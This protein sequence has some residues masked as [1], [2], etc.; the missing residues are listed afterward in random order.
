M[1]KCNGNCGCDN[2]DIKK[3]YKAFAPVFEK[4][5]AEIAEVFVKHGFEKF[6]V[7]PLAAGIAYKM[8]PHIAAPLSEI[9]LKEYDNAGEDDKTK[10]QQITSTALDFFGRAAG[11]LGSFFGA[12][13]AANAIN[14]GTV[15]QN[16][17]V[18]PPSVLTPPPP[19]PPPPA[20]KKI[21]GLSYMQAGIAAGVVALILALLFFQS[22]QSAKA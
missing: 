10:R 21:F 20:E 5:K 22:K 12:R 7:N 4:H 3:Y 8:N 2:S 18:V 17:G 11:A 6:P 14:S 1:C 15:P 9:I 13:A 19:P 16:T